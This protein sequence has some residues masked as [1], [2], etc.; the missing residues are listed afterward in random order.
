MLSFLPLVLFGS[1]MLC[2]EKFV[3]MEMHSASFVGGKKRRSTGDGRTPQTS[4]SRARTADG[5]IRVK[6]KAVLS[7]LAVGF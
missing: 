4:A 5:S 1:M 6:V 3:M 7:R 2:D